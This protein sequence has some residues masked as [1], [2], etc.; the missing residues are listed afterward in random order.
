MLIPG[1]IL[2]VIGLLLLFACVFSYTRCRVRTEAVVSRVNVK[3]TY[4]RGTTLR[5]FTPVFTYTVNG[6]QY[7]AQSYVTTRKPDRYTVGQTVTVYTDARNPE[8]MRYGSH[9]GFLCAGIVLTAAGALLIVL[10][11]L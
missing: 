4:L 7:T 9:I 3:K 5:E 1:I 11:L 2:T 10:T 6:K 8:N